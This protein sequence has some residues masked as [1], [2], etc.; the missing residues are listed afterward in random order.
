MSATPETVHH[1]PSAQT[2]STQS[3]LLELQR[4]KDADTSPVLASVSAEVTQIRDTFRAAYAAFEHTNRFMTLMRTWKIQASPDEHNIAAIM[5]QV[6]EAQ[7]AQHRFA[8]ILWLLQ[9][10]GWQTPDPIA[11]FCL[12]ALAPADLTALELE[13]RQAGGSF[14]QLEAQAKQTMSNMLSEIQHMA[15]AIVQKI[16]AEMDRRRQ[17]IVALILGHRIRP[18]DADERTEAYLAP[19]RALLGTLQASTFLRSEQQNLQFHIHTKRNDHH[20]GHNNG[21]NGKP[22]RN[23][24]GK[25]NGTDTDG[26]A[27][28]APQAAK[29]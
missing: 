5:D 3:A 10:L 22:G 11:D 13:L 16:H 9:R 1:P 19:C 6:R 7:K 15:S 14:E 4:D 12:H 18:S 29:M 21:H 26:T 25:G 20:P 27:L 24:N 23:G 8:G 2:G 17:E 28:T